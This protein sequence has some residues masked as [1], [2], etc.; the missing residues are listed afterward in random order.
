[1]H[2]QDTLSVIGCRETTAA[3]PC[4][5]KQEICKEAGLGTFRKETSVRLIS[6][7]LCHNTAEVTTEAYCDL[8]FEEGGPVEALCPGDS[9]HCIR[10]G[11]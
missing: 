3:L 2:P 11:R 10:E 6:I 4:A 9:L 7:A 8:S 5:G 1:M